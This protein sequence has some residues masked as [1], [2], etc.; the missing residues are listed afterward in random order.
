MQFVN[1]FLI[2]RYIGIYATT[3]Y[4]TPNNSPLR[5]TLTRFY[6]AQ[7]AFRSLLWIFFKFHILIF[8]D[9]YQLNMIDKSWNIWTY[10]IEI[11]DTMK[12]AHTHFVCFCDR[13]IPKHTDTTEVSNRNLHSKLLHSRAFKRFHI[14]NVKCFQCIVYWLN[15]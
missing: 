6:T 8:V 12:N 5:D 15:I 13:R 9:T 10:I 3:G 1:K 4:Q 11:Y 14:N 7:L 2:K